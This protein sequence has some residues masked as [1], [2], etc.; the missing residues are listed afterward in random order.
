ME[1][2][3]NEKE[4]GIWDKEVPKEVIGYNFYSI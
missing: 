3:I 4:F 2:I 1:L